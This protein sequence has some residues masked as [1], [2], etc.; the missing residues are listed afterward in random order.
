MLNFE[1]TKFKAV[2]A[3]ALLIGAIGCGD[4]DDPAPSNNTS[5]NTTN[6]ATNNGTN[7][8]NN[9]TN[10]ETN[11]NTNNAATARLQVIHN[12]ADPAAATVDVYVNGEMFIDDFEF[13]TASAFT[14]V[15]AGADL[16]VAV[17]PGDSSS[18]DDAIYTTESPFNLAEGSVTAVVANGVLDPSSFTGGDE[19]AFDLYPFAAEASS[20]AGARVAVFHGTTDAPAVDVIVNNDATAV[21]DLEYGNATPYV[22]FPAGG[23]VLDVTTADNSAR[24]ASFQANV[25]DGVAA[26]VLATGFL[27][28]SQN[29]DAPFG[30]IAVLAD[31]SVLPLPTAA[32]LQV[33]HNAADPGAASVDVYINDELTLDDFAFRTATPFI[34][35]PSGTDLTVDVA[36]PDSSD[37]SDSLYADT[38]NLPAGATAQ[39]IANGVLDP[40]AF[41]DAANSEDDIAFGLWANT[42]AREAAADDTQFEFNVVHGATDVP[43]VGLSANGSVELIP[44]FDAAYGGITDYIAVAPAAYTLNL[45]VEG[46]GTLDF[47]LD[48][49]NFAGVSATVL[50][51]GF[52][53][54]D[55]EAADS[56]ELELIYFTAAGGP[57]TTVAP[58]N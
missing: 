2:L 14:E 48:T 12:A 32:R 40:T 28:D 26:I 44:D 34:T 10:N 7:N 23:A 8:T 51:S 35:V 20:D 31:G 42:T 30:L 49:S 16:E 13:Q 3:A 37:S 22:D 47:D 1:T 11:N 41:S 9:A 27:D 5:N 15:P 50:A 24:V 21:D 39:I 6:N 43:P 45:N 38:F 36:G 55:D 25:P 17:A 52:F 4:D 18:V 58:A 46:V 56:P 57:A 29:A 54:T 19:I 33:I 53:T